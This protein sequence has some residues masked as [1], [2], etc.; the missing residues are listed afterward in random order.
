MSLDLNPDGSPPLSGD[1][2]WVQ[3]T[4]EVP[5]APAPPVRSVRVENVEDLATSPRAAAATV[6]QQPAPAADMPLPSALAP[7]VPRRSG[8]TSAFRGANEWL[9]GVIKRLTLPEDSGPVDPF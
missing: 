5:S 8:V 6:K 1:F 4:A 7:P 3:D 2:V 9:G